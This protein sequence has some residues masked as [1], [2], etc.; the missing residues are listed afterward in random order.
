[1]LSLSMIV[2]SYELT[3][4]FQKGAYTL[5]TYLKSKGKGVCKSIC[6]CLLETG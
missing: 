6:I 2:D 1:M 5:G 3:A 4:D